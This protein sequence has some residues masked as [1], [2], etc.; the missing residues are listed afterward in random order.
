MKGVPTMIRIALRGLLA[1]LALAG[2]AITPAMTPALAQS[3]PALAQSERPAL[4]ATV[5]VAGDVVRI[6]DLIE[7]AGPVADVPVFRAPD[8][9]TTG[10]V[11]T[12]RVIEAIRPHQL[13]D[14]DT[15][16]LAEVVVT[17]SS[18]TITPQEIS[19]R[20]ARALSTQYQLGDAHDISLN[21]DLPVH[22]LEVEARADG[23]LQVLALN[24]DTRSGRFDVT[25]ALP[26]SLVLQRHPAHFTGVAI[27]TVDAVT[28]DHPIERGEV[29]QSSDLTVLRRPKAQ[30]GGLADM[31]SAVGQ[32]A[33]RQLR[34]G[35]PIQVA[36]LMKPNIVQR[37]DTV[38]L[39]Y[40]APGLVLTLR[41]QAQEAGALGDT[42]SVLNAQTKRVVQGVISGPGRVMVANA[43]LHLSQNVPESGR[44]VV[45]P[46]RRE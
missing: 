41:G 36:D 20:V 16:G 46:E 34:P 31:K 7:N 18:R 3:T 5:T 38:T 17:R 23:D 10:A 13:I 32:A 15:R 43:T 9:G 28:V 29:L 25:F 37:N 19:D 12:E 45:T 40:E 8:L 35:Q 27:Q 33:R 4:R 39:V 26:S 24:Y 2:A 14:I 22:P 21:F 1:L 6:G 30:S 11:S 42:I 44:T